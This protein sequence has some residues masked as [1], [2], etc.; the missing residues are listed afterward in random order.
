MIELIGFAGLV[1]FSG[2]AYITLGKKD[3]GGNS[4]GNTD[5]MSDFKAIK[6]AMVN[7]KKDNINK[8][9]NVRQL[10]R[11]VPEGS[12]ID[13]K[14]YSITP[15]E[16]YLVVG[17]VQNMDCQPL[18]DLVGGSSRKEGDK[19]YLSFLK[20]KVSEVD[21]KAVITMHPDHS[22]T[23]TTPVEWS[24]AGTIVEGGDI[25]QEEWENKKNLYTEPGPQKVSLR[26]MDRN[27]NWSDWVSV[28]FEVTEVS[29]VKEIKAGA[30][31]LTV[32]YNSGKVAAIGGNRFGQLGNGTQS[33]FKELTYV[34]NYENVEHI[35]CGESHVL[36]KDYQ[37]KISSVG[38]NDFGQLGLGNRLNI[39]A[40][41]KLW[42]LERVKQLAAGKD[43]SA[44]VL[45]TGAV[46]TWG[47]NE[48]GQLGEDKPLYQELP[49]RVKN[50][51][52]VKSVALGHTHM[53]CVHYDGSV[54]AWG[55]NV[56]GQAGT[57]F[58]GKMIEPTTLNAKGIRQ[59]AAGKDFTIA[60]MENGKVMG[61]GS[62]LYGQLGL[63]GETEVMFPKELPKLKNVVKVAAKG[64][65]A[66]ALTDIGEVYTWGRYDEQID[67]FYS[68]P[69]A[70]EGLKYIKDITASYTQAYV[71]TE[72]DE[73]LTWGAR[74]DMRA[75]IDE[76]AALTAGSANG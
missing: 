72:K 40:P 50:L 22:I 70:A 73:I 69:I 43:Y 2:L 21:P 27:E 23:T 65:F 7:F 30:D 54:T 59:V 26:V 36:S 58:K 4:S 45:M 14:R 20:F 1:I 29:G 18:I 12:S 42:G 71:L 39:R 37:G 11:Y 3:E 49:R 68:E 52:N 34:A 46:L 6:R 44:A 19:L 55:D 15:D 57:G 51:S 10:D 8:I 75:P 41:Q 63:I 32:V 35:A 16:K 31:F 5:I 33:A 9:E 25:R 67:E 61:W 48:N 62:N 47:N 74:I 64:Q 56:R 76:Y 66:L 24:T 28:E 53:V 38:G 13:W 17:R 60:L